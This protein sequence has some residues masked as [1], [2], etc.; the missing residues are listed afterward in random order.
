M[1]KQLIMFLVLI[2]SVPVIADE[3]GFFT[4]GFAENS[5]TYVFASSVRVRTSP[6]IK[7]NNVTDTLNPGHE[8]IIIRVDEKTTEYSPKGV[9]C[10][11]PVSSPVRRSDKLY[12]IVKSKEVKQKTGEQDMQ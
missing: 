2:L 5:T 12:R 8:V 4:N 6:E 1:K 11:I 7:G 9:R 3:A 10:S